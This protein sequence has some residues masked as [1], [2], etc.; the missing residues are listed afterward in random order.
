[1]SS[2]ALAV[3][4][5]WNRKWDK[6]QRFYLPSR[7]TADVTP[8]KR[9]I[10]LLIEDNPADSGLVRE[11]LVENA[12]HCELILIINGEQAIDFIDGLDSDQTPCPDLMILDLNLPKIPGRDVLRR[13]R[14]GTKCAQIP[15]VILS[16]SDNEKDQ[17]EAASLG[18]SRYIRK[19][20]RLDE[21]LKLG[22]VFKSMINGP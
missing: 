15:I 4:F 5:G 3:E 22:S 10:I 12:V 11:A 18:A 19:P 1:V 13:M 6:V 8:E 16:S 2:N 21:F 17:E 7:P 9:A 20:Y 14:T